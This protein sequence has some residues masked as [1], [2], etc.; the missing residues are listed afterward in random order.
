MT[1]VTTIA[2]PFNE[3]RAKE[4]QKA[5]NAAV[6]EEKESFQFEQQEMVTKFAMYMLEYLRMTF[7]NLK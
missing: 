3:K 5:Y 7:T 1:I 6:K 4:L 2:G